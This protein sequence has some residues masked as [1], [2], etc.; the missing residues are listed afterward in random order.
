MPDRSP[1]DAGMTLDVASLHSSEKKASCGV[2]EIVTESS[3]IL[4]VP[5]MGSMLP[6]NDS[7]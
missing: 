3:V 5:V 1:A 4:K 7:G 2:T 6:P